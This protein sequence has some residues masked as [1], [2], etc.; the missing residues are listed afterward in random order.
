MLCEA[1]RSS[2]TYLHHQD[3]G[4]CCVPR[5]ERVGITICRW[6]PSSLFRHLADPV[7]TLICWLGRFKRHHF[8]QL[9]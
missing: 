8:T 2:P 1:L 5:A 9:Q 3:R 7:Q 6:N 4:H